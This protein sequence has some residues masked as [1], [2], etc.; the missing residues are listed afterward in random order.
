MKLQQK[1]KAAGLPTKPI[2]SIMLPPAL[3]TPSSLLWKRPLS[4]TLRA[5]ELR[6]NAFH[7]WTSPNCWIL[8]GK[9]HISSLGNQNLP[10]LRCYRTFC[11]LHTV[12]FRVVC[13][14]P[15]SLLLEYCKYGFCRHCWIHWGH[16]GLSY[17][18]GHAVIALIYYNLWLTFG[19]V[20]VLSSQIFVEQSLFQLHYIY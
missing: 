13:D 4:S 14:D 5:A 18:Y 15:V 1:A 12:S 2:S 9:H 20:K 7:C 19:A 6:R 16:H 10:R 3:V 8:V 17:W 11:T